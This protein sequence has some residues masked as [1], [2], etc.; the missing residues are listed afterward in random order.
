MKRLA[1]LI[2]MAVTTPVLAQWF[3]LATPGVPR[4]T[5]GALD[6]SAPTPRM[7]DGRPDLSGVWTPTNVSG[8]MLDPNNA[9]QWARDLIDER[10]RTFFSNSP[11]YH[12]LPSGPGFLTGAGLSGSGRRIV[13]T[14]TFIAMLYAELH[15]RQIFLDGRELEEDPLRTWMGYSIGEWDGDTLV[16]E[17]NGY[18]DQTWL[19]PDGLSH[20]DQLR[21]TERYSRPDFGHINVEVTY[22]D[23]GTFDEPVEAFIE[24]RFVA[25][26]ELLEVVCNEASEGRSNWGGELSEAEERS[27]ETDPET[28]A[29]YIGTYQ[30][31]WLGQNTTLDFY[32]KDGEFQLR[33]EPRYLSTGAVTADVY[34]LVA[35]SEDTFECTC[36]LGFIFRDV[37]DGVA[38]VVDEVHVS[39]AWIFPRVP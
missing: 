26:N 23:P 35:L 9:Q 5:D 19:H 30:G 32:I 21:I 12:C 2:L 15:Y 11:R 31:I 18:N 39:G 8:S 22:D 27:F 1:T 25:D 37:E 7:A 14:P 16:I 13:H 4:T 6:A 20:T 36:G 3:D 34:G 10:K 33:R 17:S 38:T 24:M 28:L 29:Q